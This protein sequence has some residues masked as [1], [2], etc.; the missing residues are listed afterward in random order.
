MKVQ[1]NLENYEIPRG[2]RLSI[3]QEEE[4]ARIVAEIIPEL[5]KRRTS[6]VETRKYFKQHLC[7]STNVRYDNAVKGKPLDYYEEGESYKPLPGEY[8]WPSD[9]LQFVLLD[10]LNVERIK[11][12]Y[13]V[14]LLQDDIEQR[15]TLKRPH[16]WTISDSLIKFFNEFDI[17]EIREVAA[18]FTDIRKR[19]AYLQDRK[20]DYMASSILTPDEDRDWGDDFCGKLNALIEV[21]QKKLELYPSGFEPDTHLDS[22]VNS[23][24]LPQGASAE[25]A[26]T[27]GDSCLLSEYATRTDIYYNPEVIGTGQITDVDRMI[28]S[29][30]EIRQ[31]PNSLSFLHVLLRYFRE[32]FTDTDGVKQNQPIMLE[33]SNTIARLFEDYVDRITEIY[34]DTPH[35]YVQLIANWVDNTI[36][37][38]EKAYLQADI[39]T[40]NKAE[41]PRT[42]LPVGGMFD[43]GFMRTYLN[44]LVYNKYVQS[45]F[46]FFGPID[47]SFS[48]VI[49]YNFWGNNYG[50]YYKQLVNKLALPPEKRALVYQKA[51][52]EWMESAL[53]DRYAKYEEQKLND[54]PYSGPSTNDYRPQDDIPKL[55]NELFSDYVSRVQAINGHT[56]KA[57]E[58]FLSWIYKLQTLVNKLYNTKL[59]ALEQ[60]SHG[61]MDAIYACQDFYTYCCMPTL[62]KILLDYLS[63]SEE[64][65]VVDESTSDVQQP[66]DRVIEEPDEVLK[67]A[68]ELLSKPKEPVHPRVQEEKQNESK[69]PLPKYKS[70]HLSFYDSVDEQTREILYKYMHAHVGKAPGVEELLYIKALVDANYL[71]W[72]SFI[73]FSAEFPAY[74]DKG[75]NFSNY[76]GTNG[77]FKNELGDRHQQKV[78]TYLTEI[79]A[80]LA[81]K[82]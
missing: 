68:E 11:Y 81:K 31:A 8:T 64:I 7:Y 34:D 4:L 39:F 78:D 40:T 74:K 15:G 36:R 17:D 30:F 18:K 19:I 56:R 76:F 79:N 52:T 12:G 41:D 32:A 23:D 70:C 67:R 46:L 72:P 50:I 9:L 22:N 71:K 59:T 51:N 57:D 5:V 49:F 21:E 42:G 63:D 77:S 25:V 43:T 58:A 55:F 62:F 10:V 80:L 20:G 60:S 47:N 75:R 54:L 1:D 69:A 33:A 48:K 35:R 61:E 38:I 73:P 65:P 14:N 2:F 24:A 3:E 26:P 53:S 28:E 29:E 27:N 16:A 13:I 66:Q 82:P 44:D 6:K 45:A 37:L